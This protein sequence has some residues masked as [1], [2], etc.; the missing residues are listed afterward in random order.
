LTSNLFKLLNENKIEITINETRKV[1]EKFGFCSNDIEED[2]KNEL[3]QKYEL[4]DGN[5][6]EIG[7][8]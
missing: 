8:E 1:K 7:K 3:S 6:I 4:P 5:M 2:L